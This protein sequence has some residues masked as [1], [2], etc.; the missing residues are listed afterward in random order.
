VTF[1]SESFG[2]VLL[3][4]SAAMHALWNALL[5]RDQEPRI[6]SVVILFIALIFSYFAIP[7]SPAP[8]FASRESLFW[9]LGA[10][11]FESGYLVTLA[12]ALES[13]S[14][15]KT[16]TISRGGAMVLVW[17]FSI[18]LLGESSSIQSLFGAFL[19]LIG[20]FLT[21]LKEKKD[22][23]RRALFGWAYLSA[24]FI[25]GYHLFYGQALRAGANPIPLFAFTLSLSL[26]SYLLSCSDGTLSAARKKFFKRPLSLSLGGIFC[27]LSFLLFLKGLSYSGAGIA[28]TLRNTSIIFALF[29][30]L[31]IG[32]KFSLVQWFGAGIVAIG[33]LLICN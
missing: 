21:D 1:N 22:G 19:I 28:I 18:T 3:I 32:E 4:L 16:Y 25:A 2:S 6:N 10:G 17:I 24:F 12:L 9:A 26:P 27:A 15:G 29:L 14:L 8:F 11:L 20:I 23:Q 5:K 31:W 30:S 7:F 33:A 13:S